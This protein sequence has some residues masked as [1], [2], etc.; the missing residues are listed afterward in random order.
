MRLEKYGKLMSVSGDHGLDEDIGRDC[1]SFRHRQQRREV[2][3]DEVIG[4]DGDG[5]QSASQQRG[6]S[7]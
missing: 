7:R 2:I 4:A 1:C 5:E 6:S 3:V